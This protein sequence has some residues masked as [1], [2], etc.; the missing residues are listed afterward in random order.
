[1]HGREAYDAVRRRVEVG[2]VHVDVGGSSGYDA[3]LLAKL[4]D[5][6]VLTIEASE[7][8]VDELTRNVAANPGL[9]VRILH[10]RVGA[11]TTADVVS[12]DELAYGEGFAPGLVKIDIEGAELDALRGATRLL[13]E[14]RPALVVE[15]HSPT[16]EDDCR[17]FVC[18]S[19]YP[20]PTVVDQRRVLKEERPLAH[21][22]WLIWD[23]H[24]PDDDER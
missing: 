3:L 22:R 18:E 9:D 6:P 7:R 11:A 23:A 13:R 19:G 17:V 12:L 2:S 10:A 5:A 8:V 14:G 15:V 24:Q 1:M 16:L 21:N 4:T 20:P